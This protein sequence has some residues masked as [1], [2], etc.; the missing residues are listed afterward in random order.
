MITEDRSYGI[1]LVLKGKEDRFLL[2]R[3]QAGHWSY[4]KGH[5]EGDETPL[6]SALRELKEES[7]ITD[8]RV[9]DHPP[10]FEEY[11]LNKEGKEYHKI[12]QY[13][14]SFTENDVVTIQQEEIS[15]YKWAT[16]E[17]AMETFTYENNKEVLK[18]AQE[19]LQNLNVVK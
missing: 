9:S 6:E 1:I 4:P 16:F 14:I 12:V 8:S 3:H 5:K 10:V 18:K 15:E 13:F 19:Y 7:G 17:E 2:L 11:M